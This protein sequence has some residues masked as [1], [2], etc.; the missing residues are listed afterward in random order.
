MITSPHPAYD[1][2]I[3]THV[4][5]PMR[6]GTELSA[7]LYLP[8]GKGPWPVL[9]TRTP[10][11][12]S[13]PVRSERLLWFARRGFACVHQD[14]RGRHDSDGEW[15][16][17]V[18][19]RQDGMDTLEWIARQS[20]SNGSVGATGGS[21]EG[22]T[23][24]VLAPDRHPSLKAICPLVPLPDPV[25]NVPYQ[26]GALFWNMIVWSFLVH[27][28][29]NQNVAPI[30]WRPLF[31]HLPL[32]TLDAAAGMESRTWQRW[33]DH[34]TLDGFWKELGYMD[35]LERVD[36]PVLHV[37]GWYDD[38]GISTYRNYPGMRARAA[39]AAAREAQRLVVGC[40]AHKLNASST[41]GEIDFGPGALIDLSSLRLRF[42][43]R[44]LAG[45]LHEPAE[46]PR[47]RIFLMGENRWRR[48]DDWPI[49][50]AR[51]TRLYLHSGGGAN[52]LFGDGRLLPEPPGG[53]QPPDRYD[54]DPR[55]PVPYV[56]D[57]A[58]LQLGEAWDQQAIERRPDVLVYTTPPLETDLVVCGRVFAE[59]YVSSDAPG[60]D[61]TG[62]LVDVWPDG[63]AIQLCD[64]IQRA[65][66][67][68]SLE[69][70]EW[71]EPGKVYRVT[72]DLWATGIRLLRGH[73]LRLEVASSAVPKFC[74]HLNTAADP[75]SET[76]PR[77]ARQT[78]HHTKEHPSALVVDVVPEEALEG[79]VIPL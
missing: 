3:R 16:P 42:F 43:A 35:R 4:P 13:D 78:L 49:P 41:V 12:N 38:D 54:H 48:F 30:R 52:T 1:L 7:D 76:E 18:T 57:P 25:L 10:Y 75:A 62:K 63:R 66:Y 67:R 60:T 37:C 8:R 34:P 71:L 11:S 36:I 9:L 45:E 40:W 68:N 74:R 44:H 24:W 22:Y 26:N 29:T 20:F 14:C 23:A 73:S 59:L 58:G 50:G 5:V 21:Y 27:G 53:D 64:G 79:T 2:D 46:E 33:L 47:C 15:E 65:E 56:T 55:S 32:R 31:E 51:T 70:A 6:D 72:V 61:F 19:E 28:R 69:R 39:T 77:V 17:F